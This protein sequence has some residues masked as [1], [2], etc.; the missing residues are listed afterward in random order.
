GGALAGQPF[1]RRPTGDDSLRRRPRGRGG[2]PL[3]RMGARVLG[4]SGGRRLPLAIAGARPLAPIRYE[5]P[6][7]SAQVKSAILLAGLWAS[8]PGAVVGPTRSRDPTERR[9]AALRGD[10]V[11]DGRTGQR[12]P[13]R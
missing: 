11:L 10:V 13:G 4:R 3:G 12:A 5:A 9:L 7:A 8:G 1:G 6:V 2:E